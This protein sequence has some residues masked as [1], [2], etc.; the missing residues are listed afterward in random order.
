MRC[1]GS[2]CPATRSA[3]TSPVSPT[4]RRLQVLVDGA[5]AGI[6]GGAT[7]LVQQIS[8]IDQLC[9]VDLTVYAPA[10]VIPSLREACPRARIRAAP[11]AP[12]PLRL[13]W[14][15]LVLPVRASRY[16]L[17]Y[18]V[19]NFALFLSP[20]PQVLTLQNS[21]HFGARSRA[22]RRA[23]FRVPMR[24]RLMLESGLA[25]ASVRRADRV[26]A[27]SNAMRDAVEEDLG[28]GAGVST[29]PSAP[30][31]SPRLNGPPAQGTY[32][33]SIA[34]D[35]F[36]KDWEGLIA[37]FAERT[38]MP[39]LWLVGA[40]RNARRI[41]SLATQLEAR[42]ARGRIIFL[43]EVRDRSALARLV[44]GATAYVAHSH[45]ESFNFTPYEAMSFNIP[46]AASDIPAHREIC[47]DA[48]TFYSA[49]DPDAL[50]EALAC[51][52]ARS[53]PTPTAP[54]LNRRWSDNASELVQLFEEVGGSRLHG[55][56]GTPEDSR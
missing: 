32:V 29:V 13:L 21:H 14:E 37:A 19:G 40:P 46:V 43:G 44:A 1:R 15:Q 2:T 28:V 8:A 48:A 55:D 23:F 56:G 54:Y 5:S 16:D 24:L 31:L 53:G 9:A 6:G 7:Y 18:L 50:A 42:G 20:R 36:H 22:V 41:P 45:L 47:G 30:T 49:G 34:H 12:L 35:Y 27:V 26:L 51:A 4:G 10:P 39:P 25:R 33:L 11:R 52:I 38:E 17:V 3:A